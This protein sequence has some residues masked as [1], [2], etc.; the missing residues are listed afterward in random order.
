MTI[1]LW[2]ALLATASVPAALLPPGS[3]PGAVADSLGAAFGSL[4][5]P[6]FAGTSGKD[7][8]VGFS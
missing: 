7:P 6:G 1:A 2:I 8:F 5:A 4:G 3:A